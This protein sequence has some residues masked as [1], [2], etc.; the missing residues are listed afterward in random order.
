MVVLPLLLALLFQPVWLPARRAGGVD[1][2]EAELPPQP[3][4]LS[5]FAL[6]V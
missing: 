4:Q 6:T 3:Q 2:L 5:S 1:S